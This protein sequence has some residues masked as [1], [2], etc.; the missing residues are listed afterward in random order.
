MNFGVL[1]FFR[2]SFCHF[3]MV[4]CVRFFAFDTIVFEVQCTVIG[5][6]ELNFSDLGDSFIESQPF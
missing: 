2:R 5:G 4:V 1:L 6:G 3:F